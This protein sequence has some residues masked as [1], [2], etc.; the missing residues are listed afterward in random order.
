MN[1]LNRNIDLERKVKI[2]SEGELRKPIYEFPCEFESQNNQDEFKRQIELAQKRIQNHP[3]D[4]KAIKIQQD[5]DYFQND[6]I[7]ATQ[8]ML[9]IRFKH[10]TFENFEVNDNN[11]EAFTTCKHF[12]D[13]YYLGSE[14]ILLSGN[15]GIGKNH[16][17]AAI[18]NT[19]A[20]KMVPCYFDS[21]SRIKTKIYDA[22]YSSVEEV[23]ESIM[24][25]QVV[26]I[27]DLGAEKEPK[28]K[29]SI[30]FTQELLFHLIDRMYEEKCTLIITTNLNDDAL[31]ERYGARIMSRI[32]GMCNPI[33]NEDF[34]H[35]I[36]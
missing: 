36:G 26:C 2:N 35:R 5:R 1:R 7:R 24:H 16:L 20:D 17:V 3:I 10:C 19:L 21:I 29:G 25:Y 22:F 8:S 14:G 27:N 15:V 12:A 6:I 9:G 32:L 34:D 23:I 11:L 28:D 4:R 13:N 31:F 30:D 33:R 18:A